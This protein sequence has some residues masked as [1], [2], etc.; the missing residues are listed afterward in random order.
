ML[1]PRPR[2][3]PIHALPA[4]VPDQRLDGH[5]GIG[6][7]TLEAVPGSDQHTLVL[8]PFLEALRCG[9]RSELGRSIVAAESG[10]GHGSVSKLPRAE[11]RRRAEA[12]ASVAGG[13]T[14]HGW[15]SGF[16]QSTIRPVFTSSR[17]GLE[18]PV[19]ASFQRFSRRMMSFAAKMTRCP[20]SSSNFWWSGMRLSSRLDT[21]HLISGPGATSSRSSAR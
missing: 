15:S 14:V 6:L 7:Q 4:I 2:H 3:V 5:D 1:R 19:E 18:Q 9:N 12:D 21:C 20:S 13:P 11:A 16:G 10:R 17:S 8:A